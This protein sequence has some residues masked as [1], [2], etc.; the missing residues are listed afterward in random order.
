MTSAQNLTR[1][2]IRII[3]RQAAQK[4]AY[5]L[6]R[7]FCEMSY[8]ALAKLTASPDRGDQLEARYMQ[9]V[10]A[11]RDKDTVRAFPELLAI[12]ARAIEGGGCDFLGSVATQMEVLNS[13]L[14]QFFTPYELSRM[15]AELT[16]QEAGPTIE[17]NG[18]ITV[19]EPASGSGGLV[20]AAADALEK[21]GFDPSM[22]MLVNAVDVSP[23]C[24]HMTY[25]QTTLRGIPA[26]V[27]LGDTLRATRETSVW[28]PPTLPFYARHGKLF[29]I[30]EA[31][32]Q[33]EAAYLPPAPEPSPIADVTLQLDL[34]A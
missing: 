17:A 8:C 4:N 5:D 14:G 23:L 1:D 33:Q 7:D 32:V 18:F 27:E 10:G 16:L 13:R 12:A 25:I 28:T 24:F 20:I 15:I 3:E 19:Q 2:F 31:P 21:D 26:L 11:Y 22:N 34:F 9:I 30:R 29:P 6:F